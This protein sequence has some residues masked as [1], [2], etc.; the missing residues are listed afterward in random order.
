M[1]REVARREFDRLNRIKGSVTQRGDRWVYRFSIP[2][3]L[4]DSGR[5]QQVCKT[6]FATKRAAKLAL[7]E[8]LVSLRSGPANRK[9]LAD[10][11]EREEREERLL[12][13]QS[14][15]AAVDSALATG[16]L[17]QGRAR[18]A[19][20]RGRW[21]YYVQRPDGGIKIG[22]TWNMKSRMQA[23]RNVSPVT[24]LA[25]HSGGQPAEAALHK[26]FAEHRRDGEW[27]A[28]SAELLAH[29]AHV[30][31]RTAHQTEVAA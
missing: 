3:D 11:A 14:T 19:A 24:L 22:T 21:V 13:R 18:R 17:Q 10:E 30:N 29:I 23:F 1:E 9:K 15:R 7:D 28:P 12:R 25:K 27:F 8:A 26:R 31:E 16:E 6:G 4:L 20:E 5:R 2:G